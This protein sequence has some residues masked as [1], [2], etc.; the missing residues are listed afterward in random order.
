MPIPSFLKT[1]LPV[2]L[3]AVCALA[4][5][6]VSRH[7]QLSVQGNQ[8]V[9]A[10]DNPAQLRGMSLFW[11][12]WGENYWN[13]N[14]IDWLVDDFKISLIRAPMG[15]E[16]SNTED[17]AYLQDPNTN[18]D[19]VETIVQAAI[20][21][22]IYVIID[23]HDHN[24]HQHLDEA[25]AF[26]GEMSEKYG[27]HPNII[28]EIFNE[29]TDVSWSGVVKPYAEEVIST[30]RA[31]DQE[32]LIIVGTP[33]WCQDVDIAAGDQINADNIVYSL[34]YYAASHKGS[35]RSKAESAL[36][37]GAA[38]FV[39][40]FGT[41]EY[42]G[43]GYVDEAE[44]DTWFSFLDQ[45]NISWAN[46]SVHDKAESASILQGGASTSGGWSESDL[47]QSGKYIR[48]ILRSYASSEPEGY[49]L[50]TST[51]G[52]GSVSRDPNSTTYS[53]GS[54]VTLS[55][56]PAQG[57]EFSGWSGDASGNTNPLSITMDSDMSITASFSEV[58]QTTY[59][60][61]TDISGQGTV[62]RDPDADDYE[63]QTD[64][65][66]T[67][68]PDEGYEFTGWTGDITSSE[69]PLSVTM[70]ADMSITANFSEIQ[71]TTYALD[72]DIS[73][74]GTVL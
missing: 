28:Y 54:S 33:N 53:S 4:Q 21:N 17:P 14:V 72:T 52:E 9:D 5:T 6:P 51:S 66:I 71:Q 45:H 1:L 59:A 8:V 67:A 34:H 15:V 46:W 25:K 57:W 11:S 47:T 32:N 50:T 22:D 30:I 43:D 39:S 60:L 48:N 27:N 37:S 41:C 44:S 68:T 40:E 73:G 61:D 23:W 58:Q 20:A 7:G 42:T 70:D 63:S 74:Q 69:N 36:S 24:A 49:T 31:N 26:F 35:L 13:S 12:Q 16:T 55:A 38:L 18:K 29:P 3:L 2:F 10:Q 56:D 65:S 62:L 19:L 64:V